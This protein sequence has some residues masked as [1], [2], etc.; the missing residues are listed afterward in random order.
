M[1]KRLLI[2]TSVLTAGL[3]GVVAAIYF[4]TRNL[5]SGSGE[6]GELPTFFEQ[7]VID[8]G[9]VV[10]FVLLPLSLVT[11]YLAVEYSLSIRR[12][13]LLPEETAAEIAG[14]IRR[15][16]LGRLQMRLA[17]RTDLLGAAL[18]KAAAAGR[19]DWFRIRNILAE[20]LQDQ[21]SALLRRIEWLNLIGNVSPMVGLFGT[22]YGMIKLFNAIVLAGGQPQATQLADGI[23]VA[24]VT[25]FWGLFIAIP[26][27][28][29]HGVFQNR[30]E[31]LINDA[32]MEAEAIMPEIRR[33]LERQKHALAQ[34]A[35]A[36]PQTIRQ[37]EARPAGT[38]DQ[39]TF[40][41]AI[42]RGQ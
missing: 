2:K 39:D 37:V 15:Y 38:A 30:I 7:F 32:V 40:V 11:V 20:S 14:T 42:S 22:V 29:V 10:W 1:R 12:R 4:V 26:A 9:P 24:L 25:T 23:S 33:A 34:R 41:P 36:K 8:G 13:R 19:G 17:D 5:A 28:A 31:A 3:A 16:G 35:A 21:A 27:L 6:G 18:A